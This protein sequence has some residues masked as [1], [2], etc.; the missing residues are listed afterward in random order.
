MSGAPDFKAQYEAKQLEIQK[1]IQRVDA[2]DRKFN[3][4]LDSTAR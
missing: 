4:I 3:S 2:A 1:D